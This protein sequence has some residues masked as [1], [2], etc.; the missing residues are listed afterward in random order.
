MPILST[1]NFRIQVILAVIISILFSS[2]GLVK[3]LRAMKNKKVKP[4]HYTFEDKSIIFTP[5]THFGQ[6]EFYANLTDSL[7][8]WKIKGY[9]VFYEGIKHKAS[10]MGVDSITADN[11]MRKWRKIVGGEGATREDYAELSEVFKKGIAQPENKDLGIDD[12]DINADITLLDLVSKYEG[13]Y[14]EIK[15]D[16]CDYATHL[17]STYTCGKALKGKL[18]PIIVDYRN[19]QLVDKLINSGQNNIVVLY[20]AIHIKGMKKLLKEK[21]TVKTS[22]SSSLESM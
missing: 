5:L 13:L 11:T 1:S 18:R 19:T 6:K 20:G 10:D 7:V 9:T 21:Q 4:Q 15:M 16:S 22:N 2:C 8:Q 3:S 17:D 14:G 12:T